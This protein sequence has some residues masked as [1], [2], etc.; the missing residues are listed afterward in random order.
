VL[1]RGIATIGA[2]GAIVV[3]S[4]PEEEFEE[5]RLKARAPLAA[6]DS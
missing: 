2:G 4:D 5:L 6:F 3:D 1:D